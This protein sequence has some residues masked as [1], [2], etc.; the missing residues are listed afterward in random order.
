MG[1]RAHPI[2]SIALKGHS[3][4]A[5]G[6]D[7]LPPSWK[8]HTAVV[9]WCESTA[10]LVLKKKLHPKLGAVAAAP[11]AALNTTVTG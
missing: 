3:V 8:D 4:R 1:R 10:D 11:A 7:A 5:L 2:H 9:A 6:P